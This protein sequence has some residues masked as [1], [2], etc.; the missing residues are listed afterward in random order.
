[1]AN[2]KVVDLEEVMAAHQILKTAAE[3]S[4]WP[5]QLDEAEQ[6]HFLRRLFMAQESIGHTEM[7]LLIKIRSN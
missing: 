2:T 4:S 7:N 1:M 3:T 6:Y 5:S